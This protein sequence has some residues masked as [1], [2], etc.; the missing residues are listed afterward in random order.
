MHSDVPPAMQL[1]WAVDFMCLVDTL[2]LVA[3]W[4]DLTADYVVRDFDM[5]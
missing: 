5:I 1:E 2:F 3:F 4:L